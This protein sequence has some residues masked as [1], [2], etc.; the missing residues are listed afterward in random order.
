[1]V[2]LHCG[3]VSLDYSQ[4]NHF[5]LDVVCLYLLFLVQMITSGLEII[6]SMEEVA[7]VQNLVYYIERSYRTP[8]YGCW[9]RGTKYND[10]TPEVCASAIGMAKAALEAI[11]GFN[12]FG[13]RGSN[14]SV[15]YVDIDAHN[16]N[17]SIFETLLPRESNTKLTDAALLSTISFPAFATQNLDLYTVTKETVVKHL[18]GEYGFKRF[19]GDG[20]G[21]EIEDHQRRYY[22]KGETLEFENVENEWPLFY[23][24]MIIDGVFKELPEQV[25]EYQALLDQRLVFDL[26]TGDPL[27]PQMYQV[28]SGE[29]QHEREQPRSQRRKV[30][31]AGR[32]EEVFLLGQALLVVAELLAR[33]LVHVFE[34]D[35]IKRYL[36]CHA[37]PKP[38]GRYSSFLGTTPRESRD[39]KNFS[40][41]NIFSLTCIYEAKCPFWS[42]KIQLHYI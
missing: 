38:V 39:S 8:G 24:N 41:Q 32:P 9:G 25:R 10:G 13:E 35:P 11:N 20:F 14:F 37:R 18:K 26:R 30:T 27:V 29:V 12:L 3:S 1:M 36:P 34:V 28:G 17:R 31:G 21:T 33:G 5:Q 7:L 42:L 6:Y 23:I 2:G 16:R 4:Y 19:I 15:I 22:H 40:M